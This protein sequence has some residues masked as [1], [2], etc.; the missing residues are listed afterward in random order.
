MSAHLVRQNP[1]AILPILDGRKQKVYIRPNP[2]IEGV[3]ILAKVLRARVFD[4]LSVW[5]PFRTLVSTPIR[6]LSEESC[7]PR[8]IDSISTGLGLII[9]A[10][11]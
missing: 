3:A 2:T 1:A 4:H 10:Q 6:Y 5:E 7:L 9:I 8:P 11:N